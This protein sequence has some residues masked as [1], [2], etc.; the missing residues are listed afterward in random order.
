MTE[1]ILF[2]DDEQN[3]LDG[4]K[5]ALKGFQIETATSGEQALSMIEASG[6]YAVVVADMRMPGMD[7]V[8][9]LARTC[10][11]APHSIRIMLTGCADQQTAIEAVNEGR[12]FRF[13]TK[14]CAPETL[15]R[16][17]LAALEQ[18]RLVMAE[19]ELLEKTLMGSLQVLTDI[20]SFVNPTAFGRASRVQRLVHQLVEIIGAEN[21]W[22]IEIAAML[23]QVGC[24]TVPEE[25]LL[26][27]YKGAT[28]TVDE[29]RI[30]Q[31][32]PQVGHDLI[33]RIPRLE[34]VAEI[35]AYQEKLFNGAGTPKDERFGHEIPFGARILKV[36]LDFDKLLEAKLSPAEAYKE[37]RRRGDWYDPVVVEALGEAIA[38]SERRFTTKYVFLYEL[39]PGM[40]IAQ[41]IIAT[42]GLL[43]IAQGQ[44]VTP[45]LRMRLENFALRGGLEEP[46]K[47][48][49]PKEDGELQAS[50]LSNVF[51]SGETRIGKRP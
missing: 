49:V 1:K 8:Q 27:V 21:A 18:Y 37:M 9:L 46:I 11:V 16:I 14:P 30:L 26:K 3:V 5:R 2:V 34:P 22:Q 43:L 40:I 6:P 24:I 17:L 7:G 42:N 47:V 15:S 12:I 23:S 20:L 41:D 32:H 48:L 25:T 31:A 19:K 44:E 38:Q 35:I 13:I 39:R 33:A 51:D 29:L 36:A 45:S 50:D 28:L 10:E 4:Y